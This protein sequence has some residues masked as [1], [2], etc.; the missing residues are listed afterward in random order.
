MYKLQNN[1]IKFL[2]P[3]ILLLIGIIYGLFN[4]YYEPNE[5]I[6]NEDFILHGTNNIENQI[7]QSSPEKNKIVIHIIGEVYEEGVYELYEGARII[8]A[9]N[10]AGGL[11][12]DA[13]TSKINLAYILKD[14]QK[15][16]IPSL[17]DVIDEFVTNESGDN[18]IEENTQNNI[19]NINTASKEELKT[20]PGIGDSTAQKIISYRN[21]NGRFLVI[22][23]IMNVSGIGN[24]K[25]ESIK[26]YITV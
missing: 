3:I 2:I 12:L 1:K 5:Y 6:L 22:E 24:S 10:S 18:I 11:T 16:L 9:V 13:D 7:N 17:Y 26:D 8:D 19:V 4:K 20:L 21:E 25:F 14:G 23:D 15:V